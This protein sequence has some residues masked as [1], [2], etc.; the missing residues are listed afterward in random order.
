MKME[1]EPF[2]GMTLMFMA[3]IHPDCYIETRKCFLLAL[4]SGKRN[5][6]LPLP[7]LYDDCSIC[8]G[9]VDL[10]GGSL[11]EVFQKALVHFR[12]SPWNA[13]L[14]DSDK[15][16]KLETLIRFKITKGEQADSF[17][18]EGNGNLWWNHCFSRETRVTDA[19]R[20]L[21]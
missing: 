9:D 18:R 15:A 2:N 19:A 3:K 1:W 20:R 8:M 16:K 5:F 13:D 14:M 10:V 4:D 21:L 11:L 12:S 6:Q 7:N 17:E